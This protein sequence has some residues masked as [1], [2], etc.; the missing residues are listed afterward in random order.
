MNTT[1]PLTMPELTRRPT[2]LSAI[3][4]PQRGPQ[5]YNTYDEPNT[6]LSAEPHEK[7]ID[8]PVQHY[9]GCIEICQRPQFFADSN[10]HVWKHEREVERK[11]LILAMGSNR[12]RVSATDLH[13]QL[14][15]K[16]KERMIEVAIA[17]E[18]RYKR[19]EVVREAIHKAPMSSG[20]PILIHQVEKSRVKWMTSEKFIEGVQAVRAWRKGKQ[21]GDK[22]I[23]TV[24]E[25]E[26]TISTRTETGREEVR[27]FIRQHHTRDHDDAT[28]TESEYSI[29]RDTHAYLIQFTVQPAQSTSSSASDATSTAKQFLKP[30]DDELTGVRV[31]GTFPDQRISMSRLLNDGKGLGKEECDPAGDWNI[32]RRDKEK[33]AEKPRRIRY[34]HIPANNMAVRSPLISKCNWNDR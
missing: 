21:G 15:K 14:E 2:D 6:C 9:F 20:Q 30:V 32:L 22:P 1:L 19:A 25:G 31:K 29:E 18:A 4:K 5:L 34:L 13:E 7:A 23:D 28:Q 10:N 12:G 33:P 17:I 11:K 24:S 26:Y 27:S 8:D 16:M 3:S